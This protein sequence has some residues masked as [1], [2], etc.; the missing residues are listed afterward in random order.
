MSKLIAG[1]ILVFSGI[2]CQSGKAETITVVQALNSAFSVHPSVTV[3]RAGYNQALGQRLTELS[4]DPVSIALEYVGVPDGEAIDA[5]EAR[6]LSLSQEF[7]FP[8]KYVWRARAV[9]IAVDKARINALTQMLDLEREVRN[10]YVQAWVIDQ[11]LKILEENAD[12]ANK[13][14]R[15]LKRL[16]E[17]GESAP[18]EERRARVEALQ[19][20][21]NRNAVRKE[22]KAVWGKFQ[23][24]TGIDTVGIVLNPPLIFN[25]PLED[26]FNPDESYEL[27]SAQLQS[28]L[29]N[30]ETKAAIFSW[31]PDLEFSYFKQNV[32]SET[33]PEFWGVEFGISLPIWFWLSGRGE[34]QASRANHRA[35]EANLENLRLQQQT[36]A[37]AL[38]QSQQALWDKLEL[39]NE[40]IHPLAEETYELAM[41]SYKMGEASSLEVIDS[42]RTLLDVKLEHL[43]IKAALVD[44]TSE[45]DRLTGRSVIGNDELRNILNKGQ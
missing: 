3:A 30:V 20:T 40:Q 15:Q 39:Y 43:E 13:Y 16:V 11:Q 36:T 45:I 44:V 38:I 22:R 24:L 12:V 37:V 33:D 14:A 42:Q 32:P 6:T 10:A 23:S 4:P 18:L 19:A 9:G 25:S 27:K 7:E 35:A 41:K 17:L 21:T 8:L 29:A 34:I 31:L 2:L 28:N 26:I 1:I 5:H